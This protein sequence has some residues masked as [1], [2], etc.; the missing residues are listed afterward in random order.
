[1]AGEIGGGGKERGCQAKPGHPT[2]LDYLGTYV[3]TFS[4]V[5][6]RGRH[7]LPTSCFSHASVHGQNGQ[8][9]TSLEEAEFEC[10]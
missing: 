9:V 7:S 5:P 6:E 1:M 8:V 10:M 2:L 4:Q 3:G